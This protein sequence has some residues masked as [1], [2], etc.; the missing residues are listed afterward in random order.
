MAKVVYWFVLIVAMKYILEWHP[1]TDRWKKNL[2][3]IAMIATVL[4]GVL[5]VWHILVAFL[6][7]EFFFN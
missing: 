4:G 7:V 5:S 2:I 1:S 3:I 6:V